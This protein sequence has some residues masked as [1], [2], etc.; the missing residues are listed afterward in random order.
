VGSGFSLRQ[1]LWTLS[2]LGAIIAV[3]AFLSYRF[4]VGLSLQAGGKP[5]VRVR[6]RV[7]FLRLT[8]R[9][10]WRLE[11]L[12]ATDILSVVQRAADR[13]TQARTRP[14]TPA[15]PTAAT[16]APSSS[17][18]TN[19]PDLRAAGPIIS[20]IIAALSLDRL[21]LQIRLSTGD[22]GRTALACGTLNALGGLAAVALTRLPG[23]PRRAAISAQPLWLSEQ[24]LR[25]DF[26]CIARPRVSQAISAAWHAYMA[27]RAAS[28]RPA[29]AR[30]QVSWH[31]PGLR[32]NGTAG[33]AY[34]ARRG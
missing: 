34:R 3:V 7:R 14:D 9:R 32:L 31:W 20:E 5:L 30:P 18:E 2:A 8:L 29:R 23:G 16:E 27:F 25:A 10:E 6:L 21:T 22:A 12:K 15:A 17:D 26:R 19:K 13:R 4:E 33:N 11:E 28:A 1:F 24:A